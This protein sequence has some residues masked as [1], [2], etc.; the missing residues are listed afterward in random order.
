M[1]N[2]D[3]HTIWGISLAITAVVIILAV[4][5]LVVIWR[6]AAAILDEASAALDAAEQIANDTGVYLAA[7]N[8]ERGGGRDSR[9]SD[10]DRG[11]RRPDRGGPAPRGGRSRFIVPLLVTDTAL[12]TVW[13][14]SLALGVVVIVVLAFLLG[15]HPLDGA[16]DRTGRSGHLG[17]RTAHCEQHR[18][19]SIAP[20]RRTG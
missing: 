11:T 7:R 15:K 9:N 5:L 10:V 4:I 18:P 8:D 13:I 12:Y 6:T 17:G 14:G 2:G 20:Q 3:L 16:G 19:Y 1:S